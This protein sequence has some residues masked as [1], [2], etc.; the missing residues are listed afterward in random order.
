MPRF[1]DFPEFKP[2]LTPKQIFQR[3][4]FGGTYWRPIHSKITKKDYKNKHREFDFG[5]V[6]EA[7]LASDR[8]DKAINKYGVKVGSSLEFWENK[9]WIKAQDPYGWVQWYCRFYNGR[10]T[11]DDRRQIDRWSALAGPNGRFKLWLERLVRERRSNSPNISP[12][13]RQTLLH[14]GVDTT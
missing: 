5:A 14:W 6:P 9:G 1:A 8:Y 2:N 10:R 3:G 7:K 11:S 13:I 12:A 4:A